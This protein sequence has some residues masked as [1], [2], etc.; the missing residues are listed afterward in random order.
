MPNTWHAL[1][2]SWLPRSLE[3]ATV[4]IAVVYGEIGPIASENKGD[5]LNADVTCAT[6]ADSL[7][8]YLAEAPPDYLV[9]LPGGCLE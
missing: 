6:T 5:H 4:T 3:L 7:Q 8:S 1:T 2:V 9:H